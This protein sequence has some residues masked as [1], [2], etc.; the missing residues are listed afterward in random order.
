MIKTND[1]IPKKGRNL[2]REKTFTEHFENVNKKNFT[3]KKN[4]LLYWANFF[5]WLLCAIF[6]FSNTSTPKGLIIYSVDLK[7]CF[8]CLN[9]FTKRKL[10]Q[11]FLNGIV[12]GVGVSLVPMFANT[13]SNTLNWKKIRSIYM[14][15]YICAYYGKR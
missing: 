1:R 8:F 7:E 13:S 11:H 4:R 10:C 3:K 15:V 2:S 5:L 12:V 14:C 6:L 9:F